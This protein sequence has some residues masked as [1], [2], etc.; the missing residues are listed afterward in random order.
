MS[1]QQICWYCEKKIE[2]TNSKSPI[3][4]ATCKEFYEASLKVES[5]TLKLMED[6]YEFTI[7]IID[8]TVDPDE[9]EECIIAQQDSQTG[10]I[11]SITLC[12]DQFD[13]DE[14]VRLLPA[15]PKLFELLANFTRIKNIWIEQFGEL[16]TVHADLRNLKHL[17]YIYLFDTWL[18][19]GKLFFPESLK[20]FDY[21]NYT[22]PYFPCELIF[23]LNEGLE[24][25]SI[26]SFVL[27]HIPEGILYKKKLQILEMRGHVK[28]IPEGINEMQGLIYLR[29]RDNDIE[30]LPQSIATMTHLRKIN[31]CFNRIQDITILEKMSWLEEVQIKGNKITIIPDSL[32]GKI[33]FKPFD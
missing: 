14:Q 4:H 23:L 30:E 5:D 24:E 27:D 6:L 9:L 26:G 13:G 8:S 19:P 28:S 33:V 29:I 11:T 16:G 22:A 21:H 17:E 31:I 20:K 3:V 15:N 10:F 7:T 18:R 32:Q 12:S 2:P 25:L 1:I